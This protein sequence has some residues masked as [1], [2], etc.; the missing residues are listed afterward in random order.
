[1]DTAFGTNHGDA[2][3][4]RSIIRQTAT[5]TAIGAALMLYFGYAHLAR[6]MG[7]DVF[8]YA[9]LVLFHALRIGGLISVG[10][11]I[12]L[13]V[14]HRTAL[15]VDAVVALVLGMTFLLSG[16]AMVLNG[17][18]VFQSAIIAICGGTFVSSGIRTGRTYRR[19]SDWG[20]V[21][22]SR[23]GR[24]QAREQSQPVQH[25]SHESPSEFASSK[26]PSASHRPADQPSERQ[27][28]GNAIAT[29]EESRSNAMEKP[30]S[31]SDAGVDPPADGFLA[32]FA[33]KDRPS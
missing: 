1:M 18:D 20:P 21:S 10:I 29:K 25:Q 23:S 27:F 16:I 31:A 12:W 22:G 3:D 24:N 4:V 11:A 13:W 28:N 2:L 9:S 6:P 7:T 19:L 15:L 33:R 8:G 17:G 30:A 32:S 5:G 14:G 26:P